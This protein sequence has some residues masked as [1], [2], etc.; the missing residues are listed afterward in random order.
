MIRFKVIKGSHLLLGFSILVLV[1]VLA[2]MLLY[3]SF[4]S[5]QTHT[6]IPTQPQ[7]SET[8]EEAKTAMAFAS[9]AND[10]HRL[11]IKIIPDAIS[12][13]VPA[14]SAG[15]ILIYHTHTHEA[16]EQEA[17]ETYAALEA[18]RTDDNSHN[19]VQLG[20]MLAED[21]RALGYTVI[22]DTTDHEQ[23]SLSDAYVRSLQTLK[24]Y[25]EQFDLCIDLHR[26]AYVDGLLPCLLSEDGTEYAQMMCLVGRGDQYS[27]DEKPN[28]QN[29]LQFA[30]RLTGALNRSIPNICRNVTIKT[31][32]YNQHI[33]KT[34]L[35][36]EVG[37]NKN[38]LHQ[39]M[40]SIEPLANG[41][42]YTLMNP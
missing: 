31:G 33:G 13:E 19:V 5:R 7:I 4:F 11:Q 12:T 38:T 24:S 42:H 30:Q 15:M 41:I 14:F 10:S 23:D 2:F 1:G 40:A 9:S 29:N 36:I 3:G 26:D 27:E 21:L 18:W 32:R 28:Y 34:S 22:H 39:A 16:Y 8:T 35:L 20:S 6:A 37:H 25:D 17:D